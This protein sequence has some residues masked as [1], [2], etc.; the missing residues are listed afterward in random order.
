MGRMCVC[1]RGMIIG[2]VLGENGACP[3]VY[4]AVGA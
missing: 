3:S 1:L 2:H 4:V